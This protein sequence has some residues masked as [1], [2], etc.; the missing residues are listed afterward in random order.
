MTGD[1]RLWYAALVVI[2]ALARLAELRIS[3]RHAR[4]LRAAG[5]VEHGAVHYPAMVFV[6]AG[7]LIAAPL[8]VFLLDR[9]FVPWLAAPAL[10]ALAGSFTLRWWVIATLGLR[11]CTRVIVLPGAPLVTRGPYRLMHHPNYL[12]VA[13]ELPALALVHTAW[14]AAVVFGGLNLIV[15]RVRVAVEEAALGRGAAG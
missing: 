3:A 15:L 1:S 10:A 4:A 9:P 11:W 2:V 6:H 5:G 13:I 12:A 14:I 8:E 7:V